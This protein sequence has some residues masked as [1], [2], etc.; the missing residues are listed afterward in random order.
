MAGFRFFKTP[1]HQRFEYKARFY[2]AEK[3]ELRA[4]VQRAKPDEEYSAEEAKRR[5]S[6]SFRSKTSG[7]KVDRSFR[8]KQVKN[9][10]QRLILI[11]AFLLVAGYI[12]MKSNFP[13]LE[14]M[15][16]GLSG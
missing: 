4:R 2:D 9:S 13:A 8:S 7:Y 3:E 15:L 16:E 5:I 14:R 1:K 6:T 12:L 11:I 10:N